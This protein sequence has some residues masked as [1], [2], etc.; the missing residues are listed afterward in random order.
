ME[1]LKKKYK[2]RERIVRGVLKS[3][4]D[5]PEHVQKDFK[6]IKLFLNQY[7]DKEIDVYVYGSY[8]HGYWDELSDYD[9]IIYEELTENLDKVL[10]D[11]IGVKVNVLSVRHKSHDIL[12]P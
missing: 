1:L 9:V 2:G 4:T 7:F 6:M 3:F 5:L 10:M 11:I 12:I 8:R